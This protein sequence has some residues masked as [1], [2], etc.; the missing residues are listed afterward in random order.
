M[1][2]FA[3]LLSLVFLLAALS[4]AQEPAPGAAEV[5]PDERVGGPVVKGQLLVTPYDGVTEADLKTL[6]DRFGAKVGVVGKVALT[7]TYTLATDHDRLPELRQRLEN[8]PYIAAAAFN[9]VEEVAQPRA[10]NDPIFRKPAD[11]PEDKDNWNLYRIKVP[12]AWEITTGGAVVAVIDSGTKADH[13]ELVGR[14]LP[15]YSYATRGPTM[16]EGVVKEKFGPKWFRTGEVRNHGTHVAV[17]IGGRAGNG[18]GTV[19]VAP[20]SPILPIQSLFFRETFPDEKAGVL[21]GTD[22]DIVAGMSLAV[23]RKASAVNMSLGGVSKDLLKD[24]REAKT[25]AD[26]EDVG[27]QLLARAENQHKAYAPVLDRAARAGVI[28]VTS[29]GNDGIPAEF[30]HFGLSRQT[31]SVAATDRD[32]KRAIFDAKNPNSSSNYGS[33]TTVSAPGKDI[34]SGIA[35]KDKL[36]EFYS[37]TSMAA[38]HA[39]GVVALMKTVDPDLTIADA[40]AILIATGRPLETDRPIGPLINARA[41]IEETR[42]RRGMNVREPAP[43]PIIPPPDVNPRLPELPKDGGAI[44]GQPAPWNNPNVRRVMR[45]WLAF[46][47]AQPPAG[48]NPN[49]RW[50]F[51]LNGQLVN[52]QTA[53]LTPR[54]V[55]GRFN[56][57]WLW[58]NAGQL[59]STN[60]GTLFEFTAGTL[61]AGTFDPAPAGRVPENLRPK[62]APPQPRAAPAG[63]GLGKTKWAGTNGKG[64]K[65]EFDF[66]DKEV[67]VK[68]NGQVN[69]YVPR[70]NPYHVP[71][72]MTLYPVGGGAPIRCRLHLTDLDKVSVR[73]DFTPTWPKDAGPNDPGA[74]KLDRT[75]LP[76]T[77]AAGGRGFADGDGKQVDPRFAGAE[78]CDGTTGGAG[79][80]GKFAGSPA[81]AGPRTAIVSMKLNKGVPVIGHSWAI[82]EFK[83]AGGAT[84]YIAKMGKDPRYTVKSFDTGTA[85]F[86]VKGRDIGADHIVDTTEAYATVGMPYQMSSHTNTFVYR[87]KFLVTFSLWEGRRGYDFSKESAAIAENSKKLIDARFPRE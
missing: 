7:N 76:A 12:E 55:W 66:G 14:T 17:T 54:P 40:A 4:S 34:W 2:R 64:D 59:N 26:R 72:S 57:R 60:L 31:I 32:D 29:A 51:N 71:P 5:V 75:D 80:I 18:V 85:G 13:E 9:V 84:A 15:G 48:G 28:F 33:F 63:P 21:N 58:E 53:A 43:E 19:G 30:G 10:F 82:R 24:W 86:I 52:N 16:Q 8:H 49:V 87:D 11:M 70:I 42:R 22:A 61:K 39:A 56:F 73:T 44:I 77:V 25:E 20:E 6:F 83:D 65:V 1:P 38:P 37:G 62:E 45:V 69:K 79:D 41:A 3:P 36:Y 46:A 74:F 67:S 50:F 81:S 35:E 23:E 68:W 78:I 47:V 27:Q